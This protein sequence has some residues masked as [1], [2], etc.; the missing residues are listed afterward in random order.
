MEYLK[1]AKGSWI[2]LVIRLYLG[3]QWLHGGWGKITGAK[4]FDASGFIKGGIAKI[5]PPANAPATFKPITAEWWGNFLQNFALPN[6]KLFNMMVP[7]GEL[8]VGLALV[9]GFATLFAATMGALMNFSFLMSG[10]TSSNPYLFALSFII[11]AWGGAYAGYL[12][13]D[14]WFRPWLRSKLTFLFSEAPSAAKN[15]A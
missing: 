8:L 14:Y 5:I 15:A 13:V 6:I 11:V 4:P 3:Y 12:G 7:W 1:G 10:S 9:L 2:W